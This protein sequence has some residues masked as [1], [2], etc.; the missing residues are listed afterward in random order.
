[1]FRNNSTVIIYFCALFNALR[2]LVGAI[3]SIY[4]LTHGVNIIQLGFLKSMQS[5]IF[6]ALDIPSSYLADKY[7]RKWAI[8]VA[9]I[10]GGLW[11]LITG[12]AKSIFGF[13][14]AEIFNAISLTVLGGVSYAY[15][16]DNSQK[17]KTTQEL[18]HNLNKLQFFFMAIA[19]LIGA[20]LYSL[21]PK[22]PWLI[23]GL[24]CLTLSIIGIYILPIP[25]VFHHTKKLSI[26]TVYS[27]IYNAPK[28]IIIN[29][30][31]LALILALFQVFLQYWQI[32]LQYVFKITDN[33]L[34]YGIIFCLILF[35]QSLS[36]YIFKKFKNNK[37]I[38]LLL[39]TIMMLL[40]FTITSNQKYLFTFCLISFFGVIQST[41]AN[42][43][44]I[45]HDMLE[46]STRSIYEAIVTSF[47]KLCVIL[48][49]PLTAYA[50]KITGWSIVI[51]LLSLL[52][53]LN[54]YLNLV[55]K[56]KV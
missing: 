21:S 4:L 49:L 45:Y 41:I 12:L 40:A 37:N 8:I 51:I 56:V 53:A 48:L 5:I 25:K 54:I 31:N 44:S 27:N 7:S 26:K 9:T 33:G 43:R 42:V 50:I 6:F 28:N 10:C 52:N 24:L 3:S 39:S 19:S 2:M 13:F 46:A 18:L 1:M 34:F 47:A 22:L 29:G 16:I 17:N 20:M 11:L 36:G 23:A 32:M 15:I 35:A 38:S 30:I 55:K 14:I